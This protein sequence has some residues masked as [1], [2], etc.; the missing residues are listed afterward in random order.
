MRR[1]IA[2][3]D[4]VSERDQE[5]GRKEPTT[6]LENAGRELSDVASLTAIAAQIDPSEPAAAL[7]PLITKEGADVT[8]LTAAIAAQIDPGELAA[9]LAPLITKGVPT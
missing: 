6:A 7:V 5:E 9:A 8:S 4:L 1:A 3:H 2:E